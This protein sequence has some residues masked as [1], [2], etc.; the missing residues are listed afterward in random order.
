MEPWMMAVW[1]WLVAH[2]T[3]NVPG[4]R[5]ALSERVWPRLR[6]SAETEPLDRLVDYS[7]NFR[8]RDVIG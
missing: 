8:T 4:W 3:T 1:V 5:Q 2:W 6:S 7:D